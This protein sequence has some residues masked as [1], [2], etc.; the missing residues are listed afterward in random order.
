M[1][2]LHCCL[3]RVTFDTWGEGTIVLKV[4]ESDHKQAAELSEHTQ[5]VLFMTVDTKNQQGGLT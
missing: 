4:P 1:I 5:Q 2:Q 3:H